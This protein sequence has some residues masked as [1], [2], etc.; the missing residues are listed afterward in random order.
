MEE[1]LTDHFERSRDLE[2]QIV[3]VENEITSR[4]QKAIMQKEKEDKE[5]KA[6]KAAEKEAQ[7]AAAAE[8]AAEIDSDEEDK[9]DPFYSMEPDEID[10]DRK[11][12]WIMAFAI[13]SK[14]LE[15]AEQKWIFYQNIRME[16]LTKT[17]TLGFV[18][19]QTGLTYTR[20]DSRTSS[21][22]T[23]MKPWSEPLSS[24]KPPPRR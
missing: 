21:R 18:Y 11:M 9:E 23:N 5:D 12:I 7:R 6:K 14:D 20:Q 8:A 2:E 10:E 1:S 15:D 4:R 17:L 16:I 3:M 19:F 24:K 22:V 13:C